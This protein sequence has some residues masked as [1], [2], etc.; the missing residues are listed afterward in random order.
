MSQQ[1]V[2]QFHTNGYISIQNSSAVSVNQF[3]DIAG[4]HDDVIGNHA[5]TISL[6]GSEITAIIRHAKLYWKEVTL[7]ICCGKLIFIHL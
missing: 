3:S 4:F 6:Y 5:N 1:K 7:A 2:T